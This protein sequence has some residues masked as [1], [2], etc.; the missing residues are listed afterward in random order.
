[1][2]SET[3]PGD[4]SASDQLLRSDI[5]EQ[6]RHQRADEQNQHDADRRAKA[7]VRALEDLR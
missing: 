3:G 7:P 4:M 6:Q 5:A 1:M 2:M